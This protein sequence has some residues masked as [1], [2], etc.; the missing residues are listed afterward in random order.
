MPS[1]LPHA[2]AGFLLA[3]TIAA[4]ATSVL[5]AGTLQ[6]IFKGLSV[7]LLVP[8]ALCLAAPPA[9]KRTL[10]AIMAL[11]SLGDILLEIH[12]L[13]PD[14]LILGGASF[15]LG[16]LTAIIFYT[17]NRSPRP[18]ALVPSLALLA[19]GVVFPSLFLPPAERLLPTIYALLLCAMATAALASRFPRRL[20]GLGALFFIV[21]DTL[22]IMRL[23]GTL[24]GPAWLHSAAVWSTY[25]LAQA[26]I[27]TGIARTITRR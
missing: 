8:A 15:A 22:L 16:H 3:A 24:I 23:G 5:D 11:G 25:W 27:F 26:L 4:L 10:A 17:K 6:T 21:S 13:R 7:G 20:T 19:W 2:S 9:Y 14:P 18:I 12:D 1:A